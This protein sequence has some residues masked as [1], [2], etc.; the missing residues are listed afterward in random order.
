MFSVDLSV[1]M[2]VFALNNAKIYSI[3]ILYCIK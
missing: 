1:G 3:A 2:A